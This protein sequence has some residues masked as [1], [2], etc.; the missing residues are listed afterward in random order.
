MVGSIGSALEA[1]ARSVVGLFSDVG[2]GD[3]GT[4]DV[5]AGDVGTGVGGY[6]M[7]EGGSGYS[8]APIGDPLGPAPVNTLWPVT[9]GLGLAFGAAGW[10]ILEEVVVVFGD[11]GLGL[12]EVFQTAG[13][14]GGG[15][16]GEVGGGWDDPHSRDD[17]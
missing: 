12:Y 4:G 17:Q 13:D 14:G 9:L 2:T 6:T 16:G 11:M 15:G 7:P 8:N 3:V 10:G 5:G 1:A